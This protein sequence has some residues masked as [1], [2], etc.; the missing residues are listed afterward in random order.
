MNN[1]VLYATESEFPADRIVE[2]VQRFAEMDARLVVVVDDCSPDTHRKLAGLVARAESRCSLLSIDNEVPVG[3]Q[4]DDTYAVA[5]AP[6]EVIEG[7]IEQEMVLDSE[8]RRRLER[9]S[10]GFPGMALRIARAWRNRVPI[11]HA[12]ENDLV[13]AFVLGRNPRNA[14]ALLRTATLVATARLVQVEPSRYETIGEQYGQ[15]VQLEEMAEIWGGTS[16]DELY[17]EIQ[18]LLGRGVLQRRGGFAE[19]QLRPIALNLAGRQWRRWPA[20]KWDQVL[21]TG[22]N[23]TFKDLASRQLAL[24]NTTPDAERVAKHVCRPDGPLWGLSGLARLG[25]SRVVSSLAEIDP[26]VVSGVI[27]NFLDEVGDLEKV[28]GD[29][30]RDLVEAL[31]KIAYREDSFEDG[32]GLLLRLAV[33]ENELWANNA[34]EQFKGLFPLYLAGTAAD[35]DARLRFLDNVSTTGDERQLEVVVEALSRGCLTNHFFRL[36]NAGA[37]GSRPN[38]DSWRP[39]SGTDEKNYV[40]GCAVRLSGFAQRGD[41][42]GIKALGSL[43]RQ[44]RFLVCDGFIDVV[45]ATVNE[46]C[47]A[48]SDW[49]EAYEGLGD[50]LR[51]DSGRIGSEQVE[52]VR[53]M[54][55][56]L[57]PRDIESRLRAVGTEMSWDYPD[58]EDL[59]Y[60]TRQKRQSDAVRELAQELAQDPETLGNHLEML[61]RVEV[62]GG[63][64]RLP[65]RNTFEFGSAV[66]EYSSAPW[67]WLEPVIRAARAVPEQERDLGLFSGLVSRIAVDHPE[68][69]MELKEQ[70]ADSEVFA[71]AFPPLCLRM[72]IGESDIPMA[73]EALEKG[74]LRAGYLRCW[75][76][77]GELQKLPAESVAPLFEVMLAHSAEG[78]VVGMDLMHMY[79]F[80]SRERLDSLRTQVHLAVEKVED[81]ELGGA[82]AEVGRHFSEVVG[83]VLSKGREDEDAQRVALALARA[84]AS[85][86]RYD[87]GQFYAA[88]V[89]P[90]LSGFPEIVWPLLGNAV[91][92]DK[93]KRWVLRSI[94]GGNA[95]A[96][97]G[98][99]APV[100][101]LPEEV[102]FAW[103]HAHPDGGP[104]F[105]AEVVPILSSYATSDSGRSIHPV[106]SRLIDE[107][108]DRDDLWRAIGSN[109]LTYG[110]VGSTAPYF[111]MFKGPIGSLES[112]PNLKVR[113]RA[114]RLLRGLESEVKSQRDRDEEWIARA[115]L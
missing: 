113:A 101:S 107:F 46:V 99:V 98:R 68:H 4:G 49:P 103:C 70:I 92:S 47:K 94:L 5:E 77:G 14:E 115:D 54:A 96:D 56:L 7:I 61:S 9:F 21:G 95:F 40:E 38:L 18:E 6:E 2:A 12:T 93:L 79:T 67:E 55:R 1:L 32:A 29:L 111:E 41:W 42:I 34:T 81:W 13:D 102:L 60:E 59:E 35:G 52:R 16:A 25:H 97:R 48:V 23:A 73:M 19:M 22:E 62:R 43:G 75:A 30:R 27:E 24:L 8:D 50:V 58:D 44:I 78:Y 28:G 51:Y 80:G 15:A 20:E 69:E 26:F 74:R 53:E 85:P 64:G 17:S 11:A 108:G 31:E 105:A 87:N 66:A 72:G 65:K 106:M 45:E 89:P 76:L 109:L 37:H 3:S 91:L 84:V 104:A 90:L 82:R 86:G 57:Q 112:H 63:G 71:P 33:A 100:L 110:W 39:S 10:K 114:R 83:W 88:L 36:G